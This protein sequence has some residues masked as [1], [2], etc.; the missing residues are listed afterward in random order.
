MDQFITFQ[1]TLWLLLKFPAK[2]K[3]SIIDWVTKILATGMYLKIFF[4]QR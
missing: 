4:G 2:R 1:T 3:Q